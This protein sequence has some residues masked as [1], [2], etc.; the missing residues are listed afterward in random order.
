MEKWLSSCISTNVSCYILCIYYCDFQI[1][2]SIA[3]KMPQSIWQRSWPLFSHLHFSQL[4]GAVHSNE[5]LVHEERPRLRPGILH[6]STVHLQWPPGPERTDSTSKGHRGCK[7]TLGTRRI[8][9]FNT[10]FGFYIMIEWFVG[11]QMVKN[12][13]DKLKAPHFCVHS[14][15][16]Y[17]GL[18]C[19]VAMD[20]VLLCNHWLL[21]Q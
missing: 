19:T 9:L 21:C 17:S 2:C 12:S 7:C 6:H 18:H 8:I 10:L 4:A 15:L 3:Y 1:E 5:G 20:T 14:R 16:H 11:T 13:A